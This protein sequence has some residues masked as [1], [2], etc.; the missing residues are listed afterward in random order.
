MRFD[1]ARAD[2][3]TAVILFAL[4]VAFLYGGYTMDRL[5]FRQIHPASIPG[6][7]PMLLGAVLAVC[8][9]LLY[10]GAGAGAG[11]PVGEPLSWRNVGLAL[12][13]CLVYALVLVG[14]VP[15]FWA[16]AVFVSTFAALFAWRDSE[17]PQSAPRTIVVSAVFGLI[18]AAVISALFRYG[19]LVRLP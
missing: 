13:T 10:A 8:A 16:T 14:N 12:A 4:G 19:F 9:V 3:I 17:G 6:L 15:F 18:V 5:E 1:S 2:R 11:A 7:V